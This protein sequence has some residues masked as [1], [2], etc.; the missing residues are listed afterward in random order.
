MPHTGSLSLLIVEP[1]F[2][3]DAGQRH[4]HEIRTGA[5]EGAQVESSVDSALLQQGATTAKH[6][7]IRSG[8]TKSDMACSRNASYA[9]KDEAVRFRLHQV[10]GDS[11]TKF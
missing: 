4:P 11:S 6:G 5:V 2:D 9:H 10:I 8:A 1:L 7:A 3:P